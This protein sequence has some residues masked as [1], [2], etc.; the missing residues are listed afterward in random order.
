MPN[1]PKG[2]S[3]APREI[4]LRGG[5]GEESHGGAGGLVPQ[6]VYQIINVKFLC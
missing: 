2:T 3:P 1:A 4:L 5:G 6:C